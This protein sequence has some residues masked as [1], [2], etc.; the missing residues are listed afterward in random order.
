MLST[1]RYIFYITVV[2]VLIALLDSTYRVSNKVNDTHVKV[3][4]IEQRLKN[5]DIRRYIVLS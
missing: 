2:A 4:V 3:S 1:I 5:I